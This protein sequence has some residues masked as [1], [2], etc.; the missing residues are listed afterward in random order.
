[1]PALLSYR[2]LVWH[3]LWNWQVLCHHQCKCLHSECLSWMGVASREP[4]LRS[5]NRSHYFPAFP[6]RSFVLDRLLLPGALRPCSLLPGSEISLFIS[7]R[8]R[9]LS[10]WLY[11]LAVKTKTRSS[12]EAKNNEERNWHICLFPFRFYPLVKQSLECCLG[13]N[14]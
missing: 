13:C 6:I 12:L 8:E 10:V 1:M 14:S 4:G 3:S 9:Q 5:R 2:N 11:A 7:L